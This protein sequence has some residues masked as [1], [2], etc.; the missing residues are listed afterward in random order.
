MIILYR[1]DPYLC[2]NEHNNHSKNIWISKCS[3]LNIPLVFIPQNA[4]LFW[5][6]AFSVTAHREAMC[7]HE[8]P[9]KV[10]ILG[11]SRNWTMPDH[12]APHRA[13]LVLISWC[14]TL[15]KSESQGFWLYK[16][17]I[18]GCFLTSGEYFSSMRKCYSQTSVEDRFFF[19]WNLIIQKT[20]RSLGTKGWNKAKISNKSKLHYLEGYMRKL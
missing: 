13:V 19:L 6:S 7:Q 4:S 9:N 20:K 12:W 14:T 10:C 15:R 17:A 1:A 16:C 3:G 5:H 11:S 18:P 2:E 8:E